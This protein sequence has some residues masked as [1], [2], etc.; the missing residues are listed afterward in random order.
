MFNKIKNI[1]N[2]DKIKNI[3]NICFGSNIARQESEFHYEYTDSEESSDYIITDIDERDVF[4][5]SE[6]MNKTHLTPT[7]NILITDSEQVQRIGEA[8]KN[9]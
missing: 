5:I 2:F 6:D 4:V 9:I 8:I 7:P 3:F 1:F